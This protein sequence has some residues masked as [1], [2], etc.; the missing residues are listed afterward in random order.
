MTR[1]LSKFIP[2]LMVLA[3]GFYLITV[4]TASADDLLEIYQLALEKDAQFQSAQASYLAAREAKPQ[5]RSFLFPQVN[6]SAG[7]SRTGQSVSRDTGDQSSDFDT[8]QY[9]INLNQVIF[10]KELFIGLDQADL[11]IAQAESELEFARQEL[12]VRV[13]RAYFDTLSA[14]DTLRFTIGEKKAIGR[15]LEQAQ[16]RFEVGLIAITDVKE[17]QANYD[18]AIASEITARNEINIARN[19][20]SVIIGQFFGELD[21]LTDRMLLLSPD[22]S[23]ADQWMN[24]ALEENL[25][26]IAT[27]LAT[28]NAGLDIKKQRAGHYPTLD[29]NAS[30][31]QTDISGGFFGARDTGQISAGVALNIPIFQGTLVNSRTREAQYNFKQAQEQ[32]TQQRRTV[33]KLARDSYLN[34]IAGISSVQALKRAVESSQAAADATQAGFEVGTRTSVDVLISLRA[35]F[36]AERDYS[37]SR[38]DYLIDTLLL[39]AAVGTLTVDDLDK[40]NQWLN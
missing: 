32:F 21:K 9:G 25:Q 14:E 11:S 2:S 15:Q 17:A 18:G 40:I 23:D 10:N 19:A 37:V 6:A 34:V 27:R 7:L 38:Y 39:K 30:A 26:L 8:K 12:L 16:K 4:H 33:A 13:A 31:D 28:E 24:K 1:I 29:L 20:L 3:S 36:Q 22:P 5:A 35:L